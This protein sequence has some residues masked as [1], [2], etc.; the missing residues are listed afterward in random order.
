MAGYGVSFACAC[1][2]SRHHDVTAM[3]PWGPHCHAHWDTSEDGWYLHENDLGQL[4]RSR[5]MASIRWV[6]H[7]LNTNGSGSAHLRCSRLKSIWACPNTFCNIWHIFVIMGCTLLRKVQA[8]LP[9]KYWGYNQD[10]GFLPW[11]KSFG[12]FRVDRY[13]AMVF[14]FRANVFTATD[15]IDVMRLVKKFE[16]PGCWTATV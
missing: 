15:Q 5:R 13:G 16:P 6:F 9:Q 4:L 8:N 10:I 7:A 11:F 14:F 12:I 2:G 3:Q 1:C